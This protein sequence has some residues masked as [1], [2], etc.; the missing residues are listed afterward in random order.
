LSKLTDAIQKQILFSAYTSAGFGLRRNFNLSSLYRQQ[1]LMKVSTTLIFLILTLPSLA[2]SDFPHLSTQVSSLVLRDLYVATF[3]AFALLMNYGVNVV[4]GLRNSNLR[5]VLI[6]LPM[7]RDDMNRAL[8][9]AVVRMF[10][11]PFVVIMFLPPIME[12]LVL[13]SPL[14][15]VQTIL[16]SVFFLSLIV[17]LSLFLGTRVGSPGVVRTGVAVIIFLAAFTIPEFALNSNTLSPL[18]LPVA[19]FLFSEGLP[20]S[21]LYSVV[22]S[23]LAYRS[24]NGF[25]AIQ[26]V[27][28]SV[29]RAKLKFRSPI[30]ALLKKEALGAVKVPQASGIIAA[31]VLG[32]LS[33]FVFARELA[34]YSLFYG[35]SLFIF[36]PGLTVFSDVKGLPLMISVKEGVRKLFVGKLAFITLVYS[37]FALLSLLG[38]EILELEFL[39]FYVVSSALLLFVSMRSLLSGKGVLFMRPLDFALRYLPLVIADFLMVYLLYVYGVELVMVDIV[40]MVLVLWVL[41]RSRSLYKVYL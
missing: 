16:Q 40:V 37:I 5:E 6:H 34:F 29:S 14:F 12:F 9:T 2:F 18:L 39:P 19:P 36:V 3:F 10:D 41:F 20:L 17:T 35:I 25:Y 11:V 26:R 4:Y 13:R 33:V 23:F 8:L 24:V 22:I 7:S 1:A 28:L 27:K 31:P 21:L 30:L 15:L 32:L 38:G